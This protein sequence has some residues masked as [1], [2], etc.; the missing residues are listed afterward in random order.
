MREGH[1]FL[2]AKAY[3]D[4]DARLGEMADALVAIRDE[5]ELLLGDP[6][7]NAFAAFC[8]DLAVD[9]LPANATHS[10]ADAIDAA[11]EGAKA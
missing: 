2:V 9:A 11:H 5:A 7:T 3:L 8:Y 4:L 10:G 6:E 1:F